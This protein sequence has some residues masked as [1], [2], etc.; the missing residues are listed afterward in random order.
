M[1]DVAER[2]PNAHS[3]LAGVEP[4]DLWPAMLVMANDQVHLTN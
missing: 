1:V 3:Y 2:Y 4:S